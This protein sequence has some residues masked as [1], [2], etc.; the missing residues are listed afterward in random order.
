[1]MVPVTRFCRLSDQS[2]PSLDTDLVQLHQLRVVKVDF[3][4][5][6]QTATPSTTMMAILRHSRD[7]ASLN[8]KNVSI[9]VIGLG[10]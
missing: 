7:M 4:D 8:C 9:F 1:M 6:V 3:I 2:A 5:I 10:D